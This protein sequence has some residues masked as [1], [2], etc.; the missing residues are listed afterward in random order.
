MIK[1]PAQVRVVLTLSENAKVNYFER[2]R[3]MEN[4][5]TYVTLI[6]L[7]DKYCKG[8]INYNMEAHKSSRVTIEEKYDLKISRVERSL[9]PIP[10]H[11]YEWIPKILEM[12]KGEWFHYLQSIIY[13]NKDIPIGYYRDFFP[14]SRSKFILKGDL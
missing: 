1:A 4:G 11:N 5:V 10:P 3:I 2:L 14:G 6:Y 12:G 8:I 13:I 9:E 7:S